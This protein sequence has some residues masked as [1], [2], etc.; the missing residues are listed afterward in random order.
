M[1]KST[2]NALMLA[3]VTY[4][5]FSVLLAGTG[6]L[7]WQV[8]DYLSPSPNVNL[9]TGKSDTSGLSPGLQFLVAIVG[10]ALGIVVFFASKK[11]ND[12]ETVNIVFR[13]IAGI[14]TWAG[15]MLIA[16]LISDLVQW[17]ARTHLLT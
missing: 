7:T 5:S 17:V 6:W 4:L 3:I 14:G 13:I 9:L 11:N 8:Y 16:I 15:V 1:S 12:K 2:L 10:I